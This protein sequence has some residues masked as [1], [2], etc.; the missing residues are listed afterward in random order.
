LLY[1][2]QAIPP[3]DDEIAEKCR[4]RTGTSLPLIVAGARLSSECPW[5]HAVPLS[6]CTVEGGGF[7]VTQGEGNLVDGEVWVLEQ[8]DRQLFSDII[9]EPAETQ[10]TFFQASLKRSLAEPQPNRSIA[11]RWRSVAEH[12]HD[13]LPGPIDWSTRL[14]ALETTS[15]GL[16]EKIAEVPVRI[17]QRET[18]VRISKM[19]A[20]WCSP[21]NRLSGWKNR[22]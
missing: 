20:I 6:K 8:H 3:P 1:V 11:D 14:E 5:R 15:G 12:F 17:N 22:R 19:I 7:G 18:E 10:T 2:A 9:D 16:F 13:Y 21:K 4:F